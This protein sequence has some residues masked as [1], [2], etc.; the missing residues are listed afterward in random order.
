MPAT[1]REILTQTKVEMAVGAH[2]TVEFCPFVHISS[3]THPGQSDETR[4]ALNPIDFLPEA[5]SEPK[6]RCCL[7]IRFGPARYAW[8]NEWELMTHYLL[9]ISGKASNDYWNT[10]TSNTLDD[11]DGGKRARIKEATSSNR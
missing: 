10:A 3:E 4:L 9:S 5:T 8:V 6:R 1:E 2:C 11:G 7:T